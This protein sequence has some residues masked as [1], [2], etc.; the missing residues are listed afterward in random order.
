MLLIFERNCGATSSFQTHVSLMSAS[1][2]IPDDARGNLFHMSGHPDWTNV[3]VYWV[4]DQHVIISYP[5]NEKVYRAKKRLH[6]VNV[7]YEIRYGG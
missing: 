1:D 7:T 4:D 3:N 2:E 6:G 5:S